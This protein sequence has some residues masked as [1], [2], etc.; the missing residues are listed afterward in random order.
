[1]QQR[2]ITISLFVLALFCAAPLFAMPTPPQD[3]VRRV[4][5]AEVYYSGTVYVSSP[6]DTLKLLDL[7][8][9]N[10]QFDSRCFGSY[11]YKAWW[12]KSIVELPVPDYVTGMNYDLTRPDRGTSDEEWYTGGYAADYYDPAGAYPYLG[13][14]RYD[15]DFMPAPPSGS[16]TYGFTIGR[17]TS[18]D[19]SRN[20]CGSHYG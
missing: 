5:D 14:S 18:L 12:P 7:G 1:M 15:V 10:L 11:K 6:E 9:G 4:Y 16:G 2:L 17:G 13:Q 8:F 20:G 19:R 3:A